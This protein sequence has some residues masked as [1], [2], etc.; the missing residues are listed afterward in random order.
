MSCRQGQ[1]HQDIAAA[2][3]VL[4]KAL[5]NQA[6]KKIAIDNEMRPGVGGEDIDT[7]DRRGGSRRKATDAGWQWLYRVSMTPGV[8]SVLE[9]RH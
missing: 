5:T 4:R 8:G 1:P 7:M 6:K 9:G 2:P 3:G